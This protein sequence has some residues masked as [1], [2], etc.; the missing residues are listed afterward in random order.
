MGAAIVS[1]VG[2]SLIELMGKAPVEIGVNETMWRTRREQIDEDRTA[3]GIVARAAKDVEI[4]A[5][6][7]L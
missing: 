3:A 7:R 4:K 5:A 2:G 6:S 1:A